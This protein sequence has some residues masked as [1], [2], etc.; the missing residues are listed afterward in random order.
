M[1]V[2][3]RV[4]QDLVPG[5]WLLISR[6]NAARSILASVGTFIA[7][8]VLSMATYPGGSWLDRTSRS[9]DL[10]RN[11]LCDLLGPVAINGAPNPV[12]S[13]AMMGA[14]GILA[15]GLGV[16]F[17]S[18]PALFIGP[19]VAVAVRACGTISLIGF[20]A[21]PFTP[22]T[23]SYQLHAAAIFGGGVPAFAAWIFCL[24][25]LARSPATRG[26]AWLGGLALFFVAVGFGLYSRE[27]FFR[28]GPTVLLPA[29]H[30][31]ATVLFLAWLIAIALRLRS[32]A[33]SAGTSSSP[34]PIRA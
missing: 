33:A 34:A 16:L 5:R 31:V 9:H 3:H 24:V 12:G 19:T 15:L 30:R 18:V 25:G 1:Q 21:V 29:S 20:V 13:A 14:M 27:Y 11:F 4:A 23:V 6:T 8:V 32:A 2:D 7:L 10:L 26:L 28:G 22:P 17:W